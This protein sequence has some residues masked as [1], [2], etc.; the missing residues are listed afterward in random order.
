[1]KRSN[2]QTAHPISPESFVIANFHFLELRKLLNGV[3]MEIK[4]ELENTR[5]T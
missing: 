2:E 3:E 4:R 5:G 1:M